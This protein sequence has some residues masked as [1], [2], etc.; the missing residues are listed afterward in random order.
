[1]ERDVQPE[2]LDH[3]H[4]ADP[5]ARRSRRDLRRINACMGNARLCARAIHTT[6]NLTPPGRVVDLGAGDGYFLWQLIRRLHALPRGLEVILLDRS[7]AADERMLD[8]LRAHGLQPR[9]EQAE[10]L[11]W[12]R[13]TPS[14]P[15]T[16]IVA[17]LFL[18]HFTRTQLVHLFRMA[19]E[20]A[21]FLC[22]CEPRR[23]ALPWAM[24]RLVGLIGANAVTR[25]DATLSV[26][27]GFVD[28]DLSALWPD[29]EGWQL[30]EHRAGLFSHLFLMR[31]QHPITIL[32]G[33][34]AG[35]T[36]GIAL[37]RNAVP[38][39]VCEAGAYPRHRVCGEF[40]CGGGLRVLKDL[41]LHEAF[42][43]AGA[44]E[45]RT[46][47]FHSGTRSYP[48]RTLPRPAL[49]LSRFAMDDVLATEFR[50][51]GGEL[52]EQ[53]RL[54]TDAPRAG[55]VRA[56]G[57]RPLTD[58]SEMKWI[59]LKAHAQQA[60]LGADLEMHFVPDGYVGLCR[61][62]DGQINVCGL[63]AVRGPLPRLAERW[64]DFLRGPRDSVLH[65]RL[66]DAEFDPD[67]FCAVS[68][69]DLRPA[70]ARRIRDCSVGDALSMIPPVTGNGMSMAFESA[71]AAAGPLTDYSRGNLEWE[72]ARTRIA[73]HWDELF[74]PRLRWAAMLQP[75]LMRGV[76][77]ALLLPVASRMDGVWRVFF[78]NTR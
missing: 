30:N 44:I 77:R 6:S 59:G 18:H 78:E 76:T 50:R 13:D 1:M 28:G 17:N 21:I 38:V 66:A 5:R 31:M 26:R 43:A 49:C 55:L 23:G 7:R 10:V 69:L 32:G 22:A 39:T 68:G 3:L 25:H 47:T 42:V 35:L 45:A 61:L 62:A 36:L 71:A 2:Q 64:Q 24:S 57:R 74:G 53:E 72:A 63:F 8:S 14:R 20:K 29:S 4:P 67:S 46:A 34:L 48:A 19:S 70:S 11:E 27:A 37:R 52:H 73:R 16:W 56:T 51:R 41:G 40:V 58:A 12:L 9:V 54:R 15:G 75:L 33:G 60:C 65:Q